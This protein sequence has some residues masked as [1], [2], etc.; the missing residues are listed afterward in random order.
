[1]SINIASDSSLVYMASK[2]K[3]SPLTSDSVA[4]ALETYFIETGKYLVN[5]PKTKAVAGGGA[6]GTPLGT[7]GGRA[8]G[9]AGVL[10]AGPA[11]LRVQEERLLQLLVQVAGRAGRSNLSGKVLIQTRSPDHPMMQ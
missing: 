9:W 8:Q 5:D 4:L 3:M 1:M 7:E 2:D 6:A 10:S 11:E